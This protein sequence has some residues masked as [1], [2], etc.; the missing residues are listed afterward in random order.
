MFPPL[1]TPL[2]SLEKPSVSL[3]ATLRSPKSATLPYE[4]IVINCL[5]S[6]LEGV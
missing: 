2:V 3:R 5:T 1:N 4:A 6:L